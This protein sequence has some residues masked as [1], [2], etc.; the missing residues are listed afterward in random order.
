[1]SPALGDAIND[2]LVMPPSRSPDSA[3][4]ELYE[5]LLEL[6]LGQNVLAVP[7]TSPLLE[8]RINANYLARAAIFADSTRL[9]PDAKGTFLP[10]A[11]PV[12]GQAYYGTGARAN[13]QGNGSAVRL[14]AYS[15][16][17]STIAA[18]AYA[19]F[20][21]DNASLATSGDS[22]AIGFTVR[23]VAAKMNGFTIGVDDS[24]FGDP[25]AVPETIDLAGPNARLTVF[26]A[27]LSGGQG[28]ISYDFLSRAPD[29]F[30][31]VGSIEQSIPELSFTTA[32]ESRFA[33][34]PDFVIAPQY[35][36]GDYIEGRFVERWHLQ[37]AT[38]LRSFGL[39]TPNAT[40]QSLF[41]WGTALS[42]AFR[43]RLNPDLS[44]YDRVM[45]SVACGTGI[46]HYI[47]DLNGASDTGDA[48]VS[49]TGDLEALPV[50][51]W[52]CGF[53]HN[54]TD[55]L[56]STITYS[57]VELDS[58]VPRAPSLSP[59]KSGDY[60]A[61]NLINHIRVE[62]SAKPG[63]RKNVYLGAEYLYGFKET[64]DGATGDAHRIMCVLAISK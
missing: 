5:P 2:L 26:D 42:G 27:G 46:S 32:T 4:V 55:K 24:A 59:Y 41:G 50:L 51:A 17:E 10:S 61:L 1:M 21:L 60:V 19:D 34:I 6:D 9:S 52:Y 54:W 44:A 16:V 25:S 58:V 14:S 18:T 57:H 53:T 36:V 40:D 29:G 39:E 3:A 49:A 56:R 15:P 31:V 12:Q 62:D 37:S 33:H 13:L 45:F 43:Y 63:A 30:K 7:D 23:R 20:V 38:V 22:D 47:V 35:V 11:I 48:A 8:A 28:L 64:L